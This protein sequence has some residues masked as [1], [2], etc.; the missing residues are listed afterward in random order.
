MN[1]ECYLIWNVVYL[2]LGASLLF[3]AFALQPA[4]R[5]T[6]AGARTLCTGRLEARCSVTCCRH[7]VS[8]LTRLEKSVS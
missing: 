4:D 1:A 5:Y 7:Q 6:S 2:P 3:G 8:D